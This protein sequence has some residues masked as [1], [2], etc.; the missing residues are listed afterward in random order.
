LTTQG[1]LAVRGAALPERLAAG[2]IGTIL[3]GKGAEE[4]PAY[5]DFRLDIGGVA[6][7]SYYRWTSGDE[8]I[9]GVGFEP[10]LI[11]F[12]SVDLTPTNLNWSTGFDIGTGRFTIANT[13]NGTKIILTTTSCILIQSD[14]SH[15]NIGRL[16]AKSSDGFTVN[17]TVGG[18]HYASIAYIAIK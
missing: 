10:S 3:S 16:V 12:L 11:V 6:F 14:I 1:D 9:T 2:V 4:I 8:V 18:T 15:Y 13:Y 5:E 7:G 17:H